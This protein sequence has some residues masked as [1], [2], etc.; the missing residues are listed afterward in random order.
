MRDAFVLSLYAHGNKRSR[1]SIHARDTVHTYVTRNYNY[2]D[3][4]RK[5]W[6]LQSI[7]AIV[8]RR[9]TDDGV[10]M[11]YTRVVPTPRQYCSDYELC[12]PILTTI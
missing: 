3:K 11:R 4:S 10:Q 7:P 5:Q 2:Y 1:E 8:G 9:V 12:A 6:K